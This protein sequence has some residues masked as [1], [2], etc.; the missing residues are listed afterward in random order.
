MKPQPTSAPK[1][2]VLYNASGGPGRGWVRLGNLKIGFVNSR[3]RVRF[4]SSA[5]GNL[6]QSLGL[7]EVRS[8]PSWYHWAFYCSNT[9]IRPYAFHSSSSNRAAAYHRITAR[10]CA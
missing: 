2:D 9:A 8:C 1:L 4:L 5:P 7:H 6:A 10:T 3:L